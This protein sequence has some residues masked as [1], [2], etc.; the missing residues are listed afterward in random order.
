MQLEF[1]YLKILEDG[2]LPIDLVKLGK[3]GWQLCVVV[4][5]PPTKME[6]LYI[7]GR[8]VNL[9]QTVIDGNQEMAQD[10]KDLRQRSEELYETLNK[11]ARALHPHKPAEERFAYVPSQLPDMITKLFSERDAARHK[12]D[13]LRAKVLTSLQAFTQ[14]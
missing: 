3:E 13:A 5:L 12:L 1:E 8:A 11:V 9:K 14:D 7:F 4:S 6:K 2:Y 10:I